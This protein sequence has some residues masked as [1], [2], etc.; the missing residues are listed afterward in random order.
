MDPYHANSDG[1][2]KMRTLFVGLSGYGYPHTRVRCYHFA[3]AVAEA[4]PEI[5]TDVL[6]FLDHLCPERSEEAMY[7]GLRDRD[8]RRLVKLA[9]KRLAG[10]RDSL[11]VVQKAHFHAAAPFAM[12]RRGHLKRGYLYDCDDYDIPLPNLFGRSFWNRWFF[13]ADTPEEITK[14]ITGESRACIAASHWLKDWLEQYSE[15]VVYIPTGVDTE[16]FTPEGRQPP[17]QKPNGKITFLWNGIVWGKPIFDNVTMALRCFERVCER[18]G[19]ERVELL[20]VGQGALWDEVLTEIAQGAEVPVRY[21]WAVAPDKM[22]DVLREADVGLLPVVTPK[23]DSLIEWSAAKSPTKLF[24]Y[25]ASGLP[26]VGSGIGEVTHVISDGA[27]GFLIDDEEAFVERMVQLV[28]EDGLR[29]RLGAAARKTIE[30]RFALP[31]LGRQLG[32]FLK[33]FEG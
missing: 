21:K 22:P 25:M 5:E 7:G 33:E 28:E 31:V 12:H 32:D 23:D 10:E 11:L 13:G 27:D 4:H 2:S 6:S 29:S 24:E 1:D 16:R 14:R 9:K 20:I 17:E 3:R 26:V 18:V 30:E 15:R 19:K 8:K